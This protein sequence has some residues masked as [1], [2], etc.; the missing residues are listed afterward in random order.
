MIRQVKALVV[1][2]LF[3]GLAGCAMFQ[4]ARVSIYQ[5]SSLTISLEPNPGGA[6]AAQKEKDIRAI[7]S[8]QLAAT[9]R[10]LYV[11]RKAGFLQSVVGSQPE[12]VFHE[13]ELMRVAGELQKGLRQAS[14]QERVAFQLWRPRGRGREE[15]SG[16][17]YLR[18][19]LLYVT[20]AKFR[21]PDFV[22]YKDA[23]YGSGTNF[24]LLYEPS[25]AVV[26]RQQSFTSQWLG[27]DP[28]EVVVD[29]RRV[30]GSYESTPLPQ[31][32]AVAAP[33]KIEP[34]MTPQTSQA[35][36]AVTVEALQRQIKELIESNQD[37]RAKLKELQEQREQSQDRSIAAE[38]T[39][40]RQELAE[41]KQL[42]ADKVLE[43]N[44]LQGRS[45]P[46]P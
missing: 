28:T 7:T 43:L 41:T 46:S 37:L 11:R 38:I 33:P 42:L 45:K 13:D 19:S 8:E 3:G 10:G 4:P 22:T 44:R 18:G 35:S 23:E 32:P 9:L 27:S 40:L 39:R 26:Q 16:A 2:I 29:I 14:P 15:T 34:A 25:E 24:E 31:T 1:L 12:S 36:S 6:G 5:D 17:I 20:L 30:T 21:S